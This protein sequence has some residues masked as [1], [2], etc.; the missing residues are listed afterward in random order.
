MGGPAYANPQKIDSQTLIMPKPAPEYFGNY[1]TGGTNAARYM[2]EPE[3]LQFA[4]ANHSAMAWH[5]VLRKGEWNNF[6]L[7][8]SRTLGRNGCLE[9]VQIAWCAK[10]RPCY[11][12]YT[13][14]M[15]IL[16]GFNIQHALPS[17]QVHKWKTLQQVWH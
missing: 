14:S 5:N 4:W 10:K 2:E 7:Q 15:C 11:N 16:S 8:I 12:I 13:R 3:D 6:A 1:T 9:S 17:S